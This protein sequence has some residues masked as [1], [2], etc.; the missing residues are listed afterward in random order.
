MV[1]THTQTRRNDRRC[2]SDFDWRFLVGS[3]AGRSAPCAWRA[4]MPGTARC[5]GKWGI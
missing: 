5:E 3:V 2:T 4:S 1:K